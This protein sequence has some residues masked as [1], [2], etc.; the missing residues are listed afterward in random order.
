[1]NDNLPQHI[2]NDLQVQSGNH[3]MKARNLAITP[4]DYNVRITRHNPGLIIILID[5]STSMN[6]EY[7]DGVSIADATASVVNDFL[8]EI[9]YKCQREDG[10]RDYFQF[11]IIGYGPETKELS[12]EPVICWDGNLKGKEW[13][14]TSELKAN[15]LKSVETEKMEKMPWGE[16]IKSITPKN[17]WIDTI[18]D[19]LTPM[20]G[21]FEL[22]LEKIQD[23]CNDRQDSYPP[24]IINITDGYP[25]DIEDDS[26]LI[27]V[28]NKIKNV[29]TKHGNALLFN[30]LFTNS[31]ERIL[32]PFLNQ[33]INFE[34]NY[35][36]TLFQCSSTLPTK[37]RQKAYEKY[38]NE[39]F[40]NEETVGLI[41]NS[42]I[43]ALNDLLNI[44]TNTLADYVE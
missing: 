26:E 32:F 6:D 23:S 41:I 31:N 24:L 30:C 22:C 15:V 4:L 40:L 36:K 1:M 33:D 19:G 43:K 35:H 13:V 25:T 7:K 16:I 37:M 14:T 29:T 42:D 2:K 39:D 34:D 10:V 3:L 28:C 11:L 9:V 44:G 12:Y 38:G 20:K 18:A 21:A 27:E 5:Q 17:I 8:N